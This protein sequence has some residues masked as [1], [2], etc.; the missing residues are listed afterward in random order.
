M[1]KRHSWMVAVF[2]TVVSLA[3]PAWAQT[4]VDVVIEWNRILQSTVAGTPTPTVFFTRPYALTSIAVFDALNSIDRVYFALS[5]RR[6]RGA[7]RL[8]RG[9]DRA[10]RS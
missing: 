2:F 10:S 7:N 6:G 9:R 3:R 5:H 4:P 8:A 1:P